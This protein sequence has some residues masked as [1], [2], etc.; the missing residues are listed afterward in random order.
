MDL[1]HAGIFVR[2]ILIAQLAKKDLQELWYP[3]DPVDALN[4]ILENEERGLA[5]PRIIAQTGVNT[6]IAVY[7]V[8]MYCDQELLGSGE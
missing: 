1:E 7:Q 4:D 3:D 6:L 2:D 8:G 5:E